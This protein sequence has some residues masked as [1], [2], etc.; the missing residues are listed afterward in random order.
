MVIELSA[1]DRAMLQ[2]EA[3]RAPAFAMEL[4]VTY[5]ASVGAP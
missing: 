2:G 5:A 1:S 4:L 3:G